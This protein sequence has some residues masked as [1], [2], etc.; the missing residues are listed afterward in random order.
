MGTVLGNV[1]G[2]WLDQTRKIVLYG[3]NYEYLV[4]RGLPLIRPREAIFKD[5]EDFKGEI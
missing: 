2:N 5:P 3:Y 4:D 1:Y